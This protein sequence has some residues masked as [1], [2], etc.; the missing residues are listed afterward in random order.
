VTGPFSGALARQV[1]AAR[2]DLLR[3]AGRTLEARA[4]YGEALA[5]ERNRVL[6]D[7]LTDQLGEL[8]G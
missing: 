7:F 6:R 4:A 3:L 8:A 5:L 1:V 2:A